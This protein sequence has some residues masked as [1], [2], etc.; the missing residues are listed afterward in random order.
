M[1][2]LFSK[3][4]IKYKVMMI[5]NDNAGKTL[6][7]YSIEEPKHSNKI[8]LNV[9]SFQY[10]DILINSWDCSRE[11]DISFY[12]MSFSEYTDNNNGIIF[13][14][15]STDSTI[16]QRSKDILDSILYDDKWKS[17]PLLVIANKQDIKDAL[18][19][20]VIADILD[21]KSITDRTWSIKGTSASLRSGVKEALEWMREQIILK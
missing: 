19:T 1:G 2:K 16:L 17:L 7:A 11:S 20:D 15:D 12:K 5:G 9:E 4:S 6:I 14:I 10:Q 3:P 8:G 21:L 18:N 13:A